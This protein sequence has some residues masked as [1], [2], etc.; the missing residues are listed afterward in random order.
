MGEVDRPTNNATTN[1]EHPIGTFK[2]S[3]SIAYRY[4]RL[5][6]T[7]KNVGGDHFLILYAFEIFGGL[8]E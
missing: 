8:I 1:Q 7:G 6:Q 3:T 5:R 4:I 2:I